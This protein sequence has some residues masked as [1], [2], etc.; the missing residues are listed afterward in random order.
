M[1]KKAVRFALAA[2]MTALCAAFTQCGPD[3][4]KSLAEYRHADELDSMLYFYG[5]V[6]GC[7][8]MKRA[9]N[10]TSLMDEE[11]RRLFLEGVKAGMEAL[12]E[13]AKNEIYNQGVRQGARMAMKIMEFEQAYN[14]IFND[15]VLIESMAY[16]LKNPDK[17]VSGIQNQKNF[18]RLY[19]RV[20]DRHRKN[21]HAMAMRHL[22][23]EAR[24]LNLTRVDSNL[25]YRITR[26]GTGEYP[27]EG[28]AIF[29]A[30]DFQKS[31]GTNLGMPSGERVVVGAPGIMPVM[32]RIYR[33]L[34][35]GSSGIFVTTAEAVFGTRTEISGLNP[36][37]VLII[38]AKLND[39]DHREE[40]T[41]ND[42]PSL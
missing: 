24:D 39:I 33:C 29:V 10:D 41:T 32:N 2:G 11:Q 21:I 7:D 31:D 13:G 30:V 12:R 15:D 40:N 36:D 37:E 22:S 6:Q 42:D 16:V 25:Y 34:D 38:T 5:Q 18:Y 14:V 35:R 9:I 23:D 28:D 27:H 1:K 17:A 3:K 20:R 26:N 8:Y 4:G 19:D